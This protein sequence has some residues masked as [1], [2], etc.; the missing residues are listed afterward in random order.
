MK[1]IFLLTATIITAA[2]LVSCGNRN[3]SDDTYCQFMASAF[4]SPADISMTIT[5]N[6][7]LCIIEVDRTDTPGLI[8]CDEMIAE[9]PMV[10]ENPSPLT[11]NAEHIEENRCFIRYQFENLGKN[12]FL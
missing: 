9:S 11:I 2:L 4:A 6:N 8:S 1:T 3:S 10:M 5:G 7:K 12:T